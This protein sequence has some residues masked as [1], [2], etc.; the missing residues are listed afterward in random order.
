MAT[1]KIQLPPEKIAELRQRQRELNDVLTEIDQLEQCGVDCTTPHA[2]R[3]DAAKKIE[4]L[5]QFY[6]GGSK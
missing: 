6:G 2:V 3:D 4:K 5:L 1:N